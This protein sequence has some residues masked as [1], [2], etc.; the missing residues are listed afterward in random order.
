M[1]TPRVSPTTLLFASLAS[2]L[3]TFFGG[4]GGCWIAIRRLGTRVDALDDDHEQTKRRLARREG[5]A[6]RELQLGIKNKLDAEMAQIIAANEDGPRPKRK[7][8][9]AN[10]DDAGEVMGWVNSILGAPPTG[11]D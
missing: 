4:A 1:R 6:G 10:G 7:R 3:F 5:Q 11:R 2:A 9:A 8:Q